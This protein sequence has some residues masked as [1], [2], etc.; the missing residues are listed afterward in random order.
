MAD[1]QDLPKSIYLQC[2]VNETLR[3]FLAAPLL[4]PHASSDDCTL[5]GF[6]IPRGT[7]LMAIHREPKVWDDPTSFRTERF[8]SGEESKAYTFVPFGVGRRQCPGAGLANLMVSLSLAA[9]ID[10]VF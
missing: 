4:V 3:L 9:S 6:D 1:E 7:M 5:G 2:I 10:S 8:R